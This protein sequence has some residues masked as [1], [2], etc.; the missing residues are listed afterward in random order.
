MPNQFI[1]RNGVIAKSDTTISGSLIVTGS[2]ITLNGVSLVRADQ[3]SSLTSLSSSF[4][5]T[6][7]SADNFTVRGTLTAQTIV[8]QT[9]TTSI[10][11]VTGSKRNGSDLTNTHEFTGSVSITGSLAIPS[12][13]VGTTETNILVADT[14]GNIFFR[15]NLSL[16]GTTGAQGTNG[17]N[18]AQGTTG[19]QGTN[20]SNG[21][22][23]TTG[24]Q[25][26]NGTNGTQGTT[27]SQGTNGTNGSQGTA[28]TNGSQGTAGTNGSQ[29]TTGSQGIQG[30]QGTSGTNGTQGTTGNTGAGTQGA[31]GTSG[32]TIL[33]SSNTWTS[34]NYFRSN[35]NTAGG[36][37]NPLQAYSDNASGA[38]MNFHRAGYYAVNFGLDSDNVMRIGGWSASANRWQLDMSGNMYAAG[39]ITAYSSDRRLKENIITIA[40]PI[41]KL[42]KLR[43]VYY[44]WKDG[45]DVLGF[46]PKQKHDIGVIAQ[47]LEEVIPE[48]IKSAPFDTGVNGESTSGENYKTVQMEKII[49]IL[50]E[51][52]KEQQKQI[53]DLK[54]QIQNLINNG[55]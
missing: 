55:K 36:S 40:D 46:F 10:D 37:S 8:A 25:G 47:E 18:G 28:G 3:T 17:S 52:A 24:A 31:T 41:D 27:G 19:A 5:S 53:E 7:S 1:A 6:A 12:V 50:I 33:G 51:A 26:T 48:A 15:S 13:S 2:D 30:R 16:Q 42:L 45:L 29:G 38:I 4:A 49:P 9:I 14:S 21:A 39:D 54:L 35:V 43:G 22:Q 20:G 32:A 23:G 44:D 11:F 34:Q